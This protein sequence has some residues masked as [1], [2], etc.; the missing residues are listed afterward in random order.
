MIYYGIVDNIKTEHKNGIYGRR[1]MKKNEAEDFLKS[2]NESKIGGVSLVAALSFG[3]IFTL[4]AGAGTA[5]YLWYKR[6]QDAIVSITLQHPSE[7]NDEVRT[8]IIPHNTLNDSY[9]I[10]K[11][12]DVFYG[13]FDSFANKNKAF[14]KFMKS[15]GGS[16]L[17]ILERSSLPQNIKHFG[18]EYGTFNTGLYCT[19]PKDENQLIPLENSNELIKTLILEETLSAYE[20]LGAK[21]IIIEERTELRGKAG[22]SAKGTTVDVNGNYSKE[23]VREKTFAKGTFDPERALKNKYFIHDFPNIKSILTGRI[24]GKQTME[25]FSET[26]LLSA[27]LDIDVLSLYKGNA[28]F[29]YNRKWYFEVEFFDKNDL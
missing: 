22:G 18:G 12:L 14:E 6:R 9:D 16:K 4:A 26:I 19:H 23:I 27:G 17:I 7:K 2:L 11:S 13:L 3:N 25:K 5:I 21:R 24:E 10:T 28:N 20:A 29:Q 15:K 8:I 1:K